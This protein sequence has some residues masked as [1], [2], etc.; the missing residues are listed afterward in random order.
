MKKLALAYHNL[1]VMLD[2]GMP[3]LRSLDTLV[4]SI[5]GKLRAAFAAVTQQVT[6][7]RPIA[8]AMAEHP[9]IFVPMDISIIQAADLYGNMADSLKMLSQ[10][11]EFSNH[12]K[13]I[14]IVL[15]FSTIIM[16]FIFSV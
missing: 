16:F 9:K 10:W 8:D 1:Y 7:G 13:N 12:L 15:N 5:D 3:I 14:I 4:S 11:Y 6:S 2:A